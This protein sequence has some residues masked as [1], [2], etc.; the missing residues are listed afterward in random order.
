MS[1]F[2]SLATL[3]A[4]ALCGC[5]SAEMDG[6]VKPEKQYRTGS[7]IPRRDGS[8]PD[9]METVTPATGDTRI[10]PPGMPSPL[11]GGR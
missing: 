8:L 5:V 7:N 1:R 6:P 10:G 4:L 2:P 9:S 3:A 11:P